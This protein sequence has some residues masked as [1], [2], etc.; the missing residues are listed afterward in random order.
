MLRLSWLVG[1]VRSKVGCHGGAY[2]RRFFGQLHKRLLSDEKLELCVLAFV[3]Y[4]A[5]GS[6]LPASGAAAMTSTESPLVVPGVQTLDGDQQVHAQEKED[7]ANTEA[8][9]ARERSRTQYESLDGEQAARLAL[10]AFPQQVGQVADQAPQLQAGQSI[11][12]YPSDNA[13]QVDLGGGKRAVIDSTEPIA[14]ENAAGQRVPVDLGLQEVGGGFAPTTPTVPV[15]IPKHVGDGAALTELGVSLTPVDSEGAPLGGSE[16]VIDGASVLYANT[17]TDTDTAIKPVA[18][19]FDEQTVLRSAV[20]SPDELYFR[21]G[22]PEGA[23]LVQEG[24]SAVRVMAYGSMLAWIVAPSAQD[25]A[26]VEVP[27]S[28]S[29]SGNTVVLKVEDRSGEYLWPVN[30]DPTVVDSEIG[31]NWRSARSG[32]HVYTYGGYGVEWENQFSSTHVSGEWAADLYPAPGESRIYE[33]VSEASGSDTGANIVSELGIDSTSGWEPEEWQ[34]V[35]YTRASRTLCVEAGCPSTAGVRENSAVFEQSATGTGAESDNWLY[36]AS[37][38]LAQNNSPSV[39]FDTEP[40]V[41]NG[42]RNV[43][44]SGGGWL[45]STA[46]TGGGAWEVEATDPGVGVD[47]LVFSSPASSEWKGTERCPNVI[48]GEKER[49]YGEYKAVGGAL[50]EGSHPLPDGEDLIEIKAKDSVGLSATA[51]AT[52]KVDGTPPYDIGVAG[53]PPNHEIGSSEYHLTLSATDG[54]SPVASS[55]VASLAF[56]VD[57]KEVGKAS[58]SCAP[59]PCTASRELTISG[60]EFPDG[61][62]IITVTATDNAGN[63]SKE[64]FPLFVSRP[65]PPVVAGPGSVNPQSGELNLSSTD[66]SISSPG[67]PLT[68]SRSYGSMHLEAGAE[69]PLGPQW[70]L[71]LGGAQNLTKLASGS[72]LLTDG[73]GLQAVF[74]SKGGGEFTAPKGDESLKLKEVTNKEGKATEFVLTSG[75][76]VVTKFTLPSGTGSV[77]APTTQE[78]VGGLGVTTTTYQTVKGELR[79]TQVLTPAPTGVSC[80]SKLMRGCRALGFVYASTTTATGENESEWGEYENHL[81]EVTFTTYNPATGEMTTAAVAAYLYDKQGRL[82]A[83]WDPRISPALKTTYGY[84]AAGHVTAET[85]PGQQSWT[86]TYGAI[87]GDTRMGRLLAVTRPSG[88]RARGS[89][90]LP[91]DT[92]APKLSTPNPVEGTELKVATGTWSNSPV[93]YSYQWESCNSSGKEC[94]PI[95]GATNPGYTPLYKEEEHALLAQVTATNSTGSNTVATAASNAVP[96]SMFPPVDS[97]QLGKEGSGSGQLK[98]PAYATL[99]EGTIYVADPGNDRIDEFNA[100]TG[101]AES[102]LGSEGDAEYKFKDPVSVAFE[103]YEETLFVADAGNKRIVAYTPEGK[104]ITRVLTPGA[105]GG[106]ALIEE[107]VLYVVDTGTD[108]IEA[109]EYYNGRFRELGTFAPAS[110]GEGQLKAPKDIAYSWRN[111]SLYVTDAGAN[112]VAEYQVKFIQGRFD[113]MIGMKAGNGNGQFK[114]PTGIGVDET[115]NVLVVDTG[116]NRVQEFTSQGKYITQFGST[117]NN[118]GQ[119]KKPIGIALEYNGNPFVVD[120]GNDRI[121]KFIP[122]KRPSD[123]PVAPAIPPKPGSSAVTTIEYHVPVSGEGAPYAMG[124]SEVAAWGQEDDPAEATAFYPPDQPMGWPAQQYKRASVYYMDSAGHIVNTAQPGGNIATSEYNST[125]DVTRTLSAADRQAAL[126]EGSKS[127]EA[128]RL[129]DTENT[130]SKEGSLLEKTLGPQHTVKIPGGKEVLARRHTQYY[131]D[132]GSPGGAVYGLPTKM[133]VGAEVSGGKEEDVRT[134]T[135]SYSGQSNLGWK[136]RQPTS[137]TDD[138]SGLNLTHK[139]T[140]EAATGNVSETTMPAGAEGT[141]LPVYDLKFGSLGSKG[142]QFEAPWGLAIEQSTGDVYVSDYDADHIVKFTSGGSYLKITGSKGAGEGQLKDPEAIAV[143]STGDLYVGDTGNHR[144]EEFN[145]SG[146]YL[147]SFGKEGTGEGQFS[148]SIGGLAVDSSGDVWVSDSSNDR[149]EEF[150]SQGKYVRA[151][152]KEGSGEGQLSVPLG[153]AI[154]GGTIYV[155]DF[156]NDR[157]QEFNLEGKYIAQFGGWGEENGQLKEPWA[158]TADADGDLYVGDRGP[159]RVEE[160]NPS[161]KFLAWLGVYGTGEGQFD[162]PEGIATN[163]SGDLYIDDSG[164]VRI[165]EWT[166]GNQG[167]HTTKTIYYSAGTNSEYPTCGNHAEWANLTCETL[168]AK[169]P[170]TPGLPQ[171]PT[172]TYTYNIWDEPETTTEAVGTTTRTKTATYDPAGR[173]LTST[174][175]SKEGTALPTV[176]EEYSPETGALISQSTTTEGKT[177]TISAAYNKLGQLKTYTDADGN[178]AEYTYDIDGRLETLN[179]GKGMQTYSYELTTGMLTSLTDTAAGT[180]TASYNPDGNILTEDYPNGMKAAYT[181]NQAGQATGLEYIKTTHCP[182]KCTW[183]KETAVP[184]IDGQIL[185]QTSSLSTKNYTYD[186]AGRLTQVQ[187]APASGKG[188]CT[189]RVYGYEADTNRTSLSTRAPG[190]GGECTTSG[191]TTEPH[192]YDT[193]DRL[194]DTGTTYDTWGNTLTLPAA[195]AGGSELT[196]TYYTDNQLATQTQNGQTLSY[197]LD[198]VGRS[199]ETITTGKGA[200]TVTSHYDGPTDTPAWTTNTS[201]EWTRNIPGINGQLVASQSNGETPVLQLSNL[202]GD[203]IATAYLSETATGLASSA[204]TTE[205]GVPTTSLPPKYSWLGA[206]QLP[207]ELPSGVIAMGIRSYVP[208]IG[209]FLQD[210]PVSGGSANAYAYT[211]GDPVNTSDPSGAYVATPAWLIASLNNSAHAAVVRAEEEARRAAEEAAARVAAEYEKERAEAEAAMSGGTAFLP[212]EEEG[213]ELSEDA[214]EEEGGEEEGGGEYASYHPRS[215]IPT[216]E[217]GHAEDAPLWQPFQDEG[218]SGGVVVN[219]VVIPP[220]SKNLPRSEPCALTVGIFGEVWHALKSGAKVVWHGAQVVWRTIKSVAHEMYCGGITLIQLM[221]ENTTIGGAMKEHHEIKPRHFKGCPGT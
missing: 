130:Y 42:Y 169:Q 152:G 199:R 135:T 16:G 218:G 84:D 140:Y 126:A 50:E 21:V 3:A 219:G 196:S 15:T 57:G 77:W 91:K 90:E 153:L 96:V 104:Y 79:P 128:A 207:T 46:Q 200:S 27:M 35:S 24:G 191:G 18:S 206:L 162:D 1:V 41:R 29:V 168:P 144:V 193:A 173:Q 177:L 148:K 182:G 178:T 183:F 179:D 63:V 220:C 4:L 114:G 122:G 88:A 34:P 221:A 103:Y 22:L 67:A 118:E 187:S 99:G 65:T 60:T 6:V 166:P 76:G 167:A 11:V 176:T 132:E 158:I 109:Y 131:Y 31:G 215:A 94:T 64:E 55:G 155:A 74:A 204:D 110:S 170:E 23:R 102:S 82:R 212:S 86:F 142:G 101:A 146:K 210:D 20:E 93:S 10:E 137:V 143:T 53:L 87:V 184:S 161:G 78:S 49:L 203:I 185:T 81:K 13:A 25:A 209:R 151:F 71:G 69:G 52:V 213:E 8:V 37:V 115:G 97:L 43:L 141:E 138:P 214:G 106:I 127:A 129:L 198:P 150:N 73:T 180:F 112:R 2:F 83:E 123:P 19:G 120:S 165:Q 186:N 211:F 192:G 205:Y 216:D 125:N 45:G 113:E 68:V 38:Y 85:P 14:T 134:S 217:E 89:G 159:D 47:E 108:E 164:N 26:G 66:V 59:G 72:V 28:M 136:L 5:L 201:G 145:A 51:T 156:D 44:A 194:T 117:G 208:Q 157:I 105:P 172:A 154:S 116:N 98:A 32:S 190:S 160:F 17:Q 40:T 107:N 119:F 58:G 175:S 163:T 12:G 202:H 92:E 9:V 75:S 61:P 111:K 33:F 188:G 181:Y 149:V 171:L 100:A 195:D 189:T 174:T 48:C 80:G 7:L 54:K 139:T 36:T 39:A 121:E 30:V 147:S 133:T 197:Q 70:S 95:L 62:D 124:K 56:A